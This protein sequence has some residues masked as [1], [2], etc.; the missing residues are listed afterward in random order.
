MRKIATVMVA[1][2]FAASQSFAAPVDLSGWTAEGDGRW[3]V[4]SDDNSVTQTINGAPTVFFSSGSE[5]Q[6]TELNGTIMSRDGDD[7]YV[8]F[9]LGYD[10]GE[11]NGTDVDFWLIDWKQR[12]QNYKGS[13]AYAGLS[14][15]H[16]TGDTSSAGT[17]FWTHSGTVQE[18]Q[19]GATLGSTGYVR[20]ALNEFSVVFTK[21]LIEVA[22][23]GTVELSYAGNFEDGAF[24]FY[25]FSQRNVAYQGITADPVPSQVPLPA[26]GLLLMAGLGAGAFVRRRRG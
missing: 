5:A 10:A 19:R 15:S 25:N 3:Q 17:D 8:G 1:T 26:T 14:L 18:V 23:N 24:G 22:V 9:V 2:I 16:V 12:N 13:R 11:L 7:D 6:G 21:T 20:N 4:A